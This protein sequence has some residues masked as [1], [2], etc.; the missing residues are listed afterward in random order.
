MSGGAGAEG[1]GQ[2][3][4]TMRRGRVVRQKSRGRQRGRGGALIAL[5]Q[6]GVVFL[7]LALWQLLSGR[8]ID[9]FLISNPIDVLGRL[10]DVVDDS[11]MHRN[12]TATGQELV[13]GWALGASTGA[14]M[15]WALGAVRI[16][17]E[18]MEPILNA[19]NGIPKV[20]LAPMFLLWFG[21]G[22]GSKIAIAGMIVFF[23]VFFNV[24]SGMRTVPQPLCEVARAMGASRMFV[25]RKVVLPSVSVP[26]F[27]GL[28]AGVSFAMIGVIAAEFISAD[29]GLG[30]YSMT[31]TQQ[32]DPSG[33]FAALV[34]IVA[35]VVAGTA[36][37]GVFEQ[38][39]LKWQR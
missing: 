24:Y 14:V 31:S 15:G 35:M 18:I 32:F 12:I 38:R 26:L 20:A 11:A 30:Y 2:E 23:L 21:L 7:I 10:V 34:I 9:Y 6:F 16:V 3:Q 28:K 4:L 25:V 22:I 1:G 33:L 29:V 27:A 19:I 8:V 17:G 13:L 36:I 5:G 39:A 37:I